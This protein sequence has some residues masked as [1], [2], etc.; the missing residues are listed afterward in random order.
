MRRL[1]EGS[2]ER[3]LEETSEDTWW[4]SVGEKVRIYPGPEMCNLIVKP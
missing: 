2:K 4:K 3:P 1:F